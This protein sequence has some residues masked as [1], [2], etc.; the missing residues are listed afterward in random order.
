MGMKGSDHLVA[1]EGHAGIV[2]PSIVIVHKGELE[3]PEGHEAVTIDP[4][5]AAESVWR[6]V[7]ADVADQDAAWPTHDPLKLGR[8]LEH[9]YVGNS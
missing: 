7:D 6:V 5:F 1:L 2:G 8:V 4:D 9:L 3:V